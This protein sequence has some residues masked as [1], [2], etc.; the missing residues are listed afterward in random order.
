[1]ELLEAIVLNNNQI[2]GSIPQRVGDL[3]ALQFLYAFLQCYQFIST[4]TR[5]TVFSETMPFQEP[6]LPPLAT[7]L[8]FRDCMVDS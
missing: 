5:F 8:H 6:S 2:E 4:D 1:M 7:S 3:V